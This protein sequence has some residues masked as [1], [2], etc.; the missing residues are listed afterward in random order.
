MAFDG[1]Q[2]NLSGVPDYLT[3]CLGEDGNWGSA[4][5]MAVRESLSRGS[6][7]GVMD[8]FNVM[9]TQDMAGALREAGFAVSE[10]LV[11]RG[12]EAVLADVQF[13]LIAAI[14][15][16]MD[17]FGLAEARAQ[18]MAGGAGFAAKEVDAADSNFVPM[19]F[20]GDVEAL[21]AVQRV[22]SSASVEV[23]LLGDAVPGDRGALLF[24]AG[25]ALQKRL[26]G[27]A[28]EGIPGKYEVPLAMNEMVGLYRE[29]TRAVALESTRVAL[30][31]WSSGEK[32]D[33]INEWIPDS[34]QRLLQGSVSVSAATLVVNAIEGGMVG[35]H[36]GE[37][38]VHTF[39]RLLKEQGYDVNAATIGRQA[40][41]MGLTMVEPDRRRGQYF[42]SMVGVDH[43]AALIKFCKDGAVELP[44]K[45]LAA[46][47]RRPV[48]GD[49]VK[50]KFSNEALVVNVQERAGARDFG[51]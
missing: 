16:R 44:F 23:D 36:A 37:I 41:E 43:R 22:M 14:D 35:R 39:T 45:D 32:V 48:V 33:E 49:S 40:E 42:G 3:P 9:D 50:M 47:Q 18:E 31:M 46:G 20:S 10:G 27:F 6:I 4:G 11:E 1:V 15:L 7:D 5:G 21:R 17:G 29:S 25:Q 12:R 26:Q 2:L 34:V 13:D 24:V 51:R 8:L 28:F 30:A 19:G 38:G